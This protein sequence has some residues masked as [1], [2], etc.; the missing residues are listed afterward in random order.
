VSGVSIDDGREGLVALREERAFVDLSSWRKVRVSGADAVAWLHD[1]LTADIEGLAPGEA[2]RSLLLTPTGKVR[3]DVH[4][5]RREDDV[6]L[7]QDDD[8]PEHIGLLLHPYIL[9]S[10]VTLEDATHDLTLVAVPGAAASRVGTPGTTPSTLGSGIDV[11]LPSG[12]PSW[13]LEDALLKADLVEAGPEAVEAWR[14]EDGRPRMGRDFGPDSLPAEAGLEPLI[15]LTKGCFLGQE[16]IAKVRN[17]GHPTRILRHVRI[18]GDARVGEVVLSDTT[19][20]GELTSVTP[21]EGGALAI[22]RVRWDAGDAPL[23]LTDGRLCTE[24]PQSG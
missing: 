4:V 11:V 19:A 16:S 14:I 22:A 1:L 7:L 12:K 13:R 9:S 17:L 2:T 10:D 20:V 15:D 18:A 8:Q 21:V 24:V 3:A 5:I 6:L 23:A